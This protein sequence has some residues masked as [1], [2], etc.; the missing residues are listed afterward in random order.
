MH[1]VRLLL[2]DGCYAG[3][4]TGFIDLLHFANQIA[5]RKGWP[6]P[7]HWQVFSLD[8]LPVTTASGIQLTPDGD[9]ALAEAAPWCCRR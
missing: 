9:T 1:Q 6:A 3:S 8:G 7:F 2:L 5:A 4:V